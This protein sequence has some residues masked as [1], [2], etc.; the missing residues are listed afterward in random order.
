MISRE[1]CAL[2]TLTVQ[3]IVRKKIVLIVYLIV[4]NESLI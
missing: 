2:K 1:A 3:W 4:V